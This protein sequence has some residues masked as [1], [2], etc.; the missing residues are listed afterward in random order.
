MGETLT[1]NRANQGDFRVD[2]NTST[3]DKVFGRVLVRRVPG[4]DDKRAMPLLL[5][6]QTDAPFRNVAVNWNRVVKPSLVN[7]VLVGFNQITIV[8]RDDSTGPGSGTPTPR[9]GSPAGSRLPG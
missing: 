3:K 4:Q 5:G 1:T 9:S 8:G 7:E 2:W 6:S